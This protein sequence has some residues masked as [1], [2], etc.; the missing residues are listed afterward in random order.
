MANEEDKKDAAPAEG[1]PKK[2]RPAK[3]QGG[4]KKKAA[5]PTGPAPKYKRESPPKLKKLYDTQVRVQ[6]K[7]EFSYSSIMQAPP[8]VKVTVNMG[9][10]KAK[11]EPKMIDN[12]IE[13]LKQITGQSPVVSRATRRI[14][15]NGAPSLMT[16]STSGTPPATALARASFMACCVLDRISATVSD[17]AST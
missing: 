13:E 3:A 6:L 8:V 7:T 9:L 12:A 14:S 4:G 1:A 17:E 15:V 5:E 11:D 2:E 16:M 10:G